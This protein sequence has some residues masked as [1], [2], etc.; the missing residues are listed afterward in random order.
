MSAILNQRAQHQKVFPLYVLF[1]TRVEGGQE[2][3]YEWV[4]IVGKGEC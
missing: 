1:G 3:V 4:P 2:I